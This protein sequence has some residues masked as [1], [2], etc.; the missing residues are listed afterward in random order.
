[1]G[2]LMTSPWIYRGIRWLLGGV[3]VYSGIVK[4]LDIASFAAV[5]DAYGIVPWQVRTLTA[6]LIAWTEVLAGAA[7][8]VDIR[9]SL[10]TVAGLLVL[11]LA[12]LGYG[13]TLG[14]DIDCG[15]FG[16]G[17]P[18]GEA[19]HGL[20]AAFYKDVA[21]MLGVVWCYVW[22]YVTGVRPVSPGTWLT[23]LIKRRCEE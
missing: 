18:V 14:L 7:L 23:P 4:I 3:F 13:I 1:M 8:L 2:W 17:D 19:F 6:V 20:R 22:R 10:G 5:I 9:G 12:V 16:Q 15:C 11:F 21:M